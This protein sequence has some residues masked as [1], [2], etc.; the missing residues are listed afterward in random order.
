[1]SFWRKQALSE[2][3]A[4]AQY[5]KHQLNRTLGTFDLIMVGIGA[6]IGAGLFTITGIAAAGNAGPAI[7]IS[8]ILGAIGCAFA[9]MCY[10]ELASMIPSSGSAYTYTYASMGEFP[11]WLMGWSLVLEYAIGAGVVSISWSA[12]VVALLHDFGLD[13]PR[14]IISSPWQKESILASTDS[15]FFNLPAVF[16]VVLIS[17]ILSRGIRQSVIVNGIAVITKVAVVVLFISIG[18]FYIDPQNYDPFIPENTGT[19]G[20][21]GWSGILRASGV[22]F[23]AYIGFDAIST[24][25]L[26]TKNPQ[27]SI[28]I[29]ILGSLL[30]CTVI[31]ILFAFVLTGIVNYK[32]LGV[33]APIAVAVSKTPY[34]WLRGLINIAVLSGL[35]SVI[36]VM[37]LG[38]SRVFYVMAN[39]GLLP[40]TF[41][42]L[43]PKYKTPWISNLIVMTFVSIIVA[44]VPISVVGHMTSIGTL[45]A[46][47]MVC[48]GV[49]I[50]RYRYPEHA[51]SFRVPVFPLFPILGILSCLLMMVSLDMETWARFIIWLIVG[52]VIYAVYGYSHSRYSNQSMP[53]PK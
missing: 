12:Y 26:E 42:K 52:V 21:F 50:L 4:E 40:K 22:L 36:L 6:V 8:F 2:L 35:T 31:Y 32:D 5:E 41:S 3:N 51:R 37:L 9:G 44:F 29:G 18:I 30:I 25:A 27:R 53:T 33:A 48:V 14:E 43:H 20:Q 38:Q 49:I 10:C 34:T 23:F 17:L 1:M 28:P 13:L 46:F 7:V 15:P 11:A 45:L 47:V 19:F 16:I 39:D 24:T